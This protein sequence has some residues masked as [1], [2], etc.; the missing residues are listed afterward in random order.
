MEWA[1]QL[2]EVLELLS[3]EVFKERLGGTSCCV[4]VDE[5]MIGRRLDLM[6]SEVFS[7]LS[8]S[9]T[10]SSPP[11]VLMDVDVLPVELWQ[12]LCHLCLPSCRAAA[13]AGLAGA[14]SGLPGAQTGPTSLAWS[15]GP[16]EK[17]SS[18][19]GWP[20]KP[21]ACRTWSPPGTCPCSS[22]GGAGAMATTG[23]CDWLAL[24]PGTRGAG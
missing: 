24:L 12:L 16:G 8:G 19:T 17:L 15:C 14:V 2:R 10:L 21:G 6:T 20:P 5:V 22:G 3:L 1:L 11:E 13:A 4:I 18:S 23:P 9:V 7:H